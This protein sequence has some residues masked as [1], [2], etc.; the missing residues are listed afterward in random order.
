MDRNLQTTTEGEGT[1]VGYTVP[2]AQCTKRFSA[3]C[4]NDPLLH[5]FMCY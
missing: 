3:L 1:I 2:T 5:A 4:I